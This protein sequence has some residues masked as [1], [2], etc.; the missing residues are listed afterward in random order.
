[1]R[2]TMDKA[3]RIV[4]PSQLRA[5]IG[6]EPGPVDI[7]IDGSGL[8]VEIPE[9]DNVVEREGL[10]MIDAEGPETTADDVRELRLAVQ[11]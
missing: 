5:Q 10:L 2:T 11:R 1:M 4:V 9:E 7:S 3:G 6:L 8:R